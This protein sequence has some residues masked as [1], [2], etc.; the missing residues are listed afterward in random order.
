ML[1]IRDLKL[2][3]G[4]READLIDRIASVLHCAKRD[5][6]SVRTVRRAIDARRKD[7]VRMVVTADISMDAKTEN[8]ILKK[9]IKG[10]ERPLPV[11]YRIPKT[12]IYPELRP[13][14]TG[15]GPA[16]MFCA[17]VL[18][19]AG[20]RPV[21]IERGSRA[22]ERQHRVELLR[23]EGVLDIECN[24]QFGEGGAGTFSDGKLYTGVNDMRIPFILETF[25]RHGA[26]EEITYDS[27][28]HIGTDVLVT[29]VAGIRREIESSGG[30]I[31]FDTRLDD[32]ETSGGK[33][34]G[35]ICSD[36]TGNQ[37]HISTDTLVLATGHSA[38]DTFAMLESRGVGMEPKAFAMGV[39]IEHSQD[40]LNRLQFGDY[41]DI[42]PPAD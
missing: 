14:I 15:F 35:V 40:W 33:I 24:V 20:L 39:R 9:R 23:R 17:L 27:K 11:K 1:R 6:L 41:S 19:K 29:V 34:A 16:G 22:E 26:G 32:I 25:A 2:E 18:A 10:V 12:E 36:R 7:S 42:L 30:E 37:L 5:I 38:R 3:P 28:P 31:L 21:V 13:V 4:Y 8:R